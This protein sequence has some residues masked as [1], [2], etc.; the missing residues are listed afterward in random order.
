VLNGRFASGSY[1]AVGL[2]NSAGKVVFFGKSNYIYEYFEA[3]EMVDGET[4]GIL[5]ER[6]GD[7]VFEFKV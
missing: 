1:H 7:E 3:G 6:M 4:M 2:N 5:P